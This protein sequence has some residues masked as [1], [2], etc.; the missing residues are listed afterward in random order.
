V[1]RK[2]KK[3][4]KKEKRVADQHGKT[5]RA[6]TTNG[7]PGDHGKVKQAGESYQGKRK[8]RKITAWGD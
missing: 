8:T 4:S 1:E 7:A 5:D 3:K 2:G 6:T